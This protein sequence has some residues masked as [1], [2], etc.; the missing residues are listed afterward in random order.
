MN[1]YQI[2]IAPL[3]SEKTT[4]LREQG[5]YGFKV[6]KN[7][8]KIEIMRAIQ[9]LFGVTPLR[10][11]IVNIKPKPMRVRNIP[12]RKAQVKKAYIQLSPQQTLAQLEGTGSGN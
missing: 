9:E 10:C 3:L 5:I 6:H 4:A 7:A 2:V 12:G 8:N 11:N 1:A